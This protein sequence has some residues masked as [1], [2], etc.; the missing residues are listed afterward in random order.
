[1]DNET[2]LKKAIVIAKNNGYLINKN[3]E[4]IINKGEH[5]FEGEA[6]FIRE[7]YCNY[8]HIN[9]I[10]FSNN[11]AKAFWG[12][13]FY[14]EKGKRNGYYEWEHHLQIMVILEEP[15]K[16]LERFLDDK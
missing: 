2:I 4:M 12:G 15:L 9:E 3:I 16:Y 11:F 7:A 14:R 10:I 5:D 6:G 8:F 13:L 1:M